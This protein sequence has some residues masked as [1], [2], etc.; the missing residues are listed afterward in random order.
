[1]TTEALERAMDLASEAIKDRGGH[2]MKSGGAKAESAYGV[3]YQ[4][5][6]RVG[7]R[8]QIRGRYR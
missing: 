8:P 3:A 2:S 1:M 6:V 4:A 5:L 7:R